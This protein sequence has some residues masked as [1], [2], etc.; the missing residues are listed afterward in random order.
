MKKDTNILAELTTVA[1]LLATINNSMPYGV[2]NNY[3]IGLSEAI[4]SQISAENL[5]KIATPFTVPQDYFATL[6]SRVLATIAQ[7]TGSKNEVIAELE[8]VAPILNTIDKRNIYA[9]PEGYF[10]KFKANI[11]DATYSARVVSMTSF[12]RKMLYIAAACVISLMAISAFIF[13]KSTGKIDYAAYK[14]IDINSNIDKIS[15]E[16][17]LNYLENVNSITNSNALTTIDVKLPELQDH[18]QSIPDEE[19][20]EYLKEADL[21][22][23]EEQQPGI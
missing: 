18:I 2:P 10:T 21:P 14:K 7:E 8:A 22:S 17:L 9:L 19:L 1:P 13:T 23:G 20:K 11:S 15:S 16:E 5:P 12:K 6:S 3:F 4:L